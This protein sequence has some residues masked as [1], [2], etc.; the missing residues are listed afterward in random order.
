MDAVVLQEFLDFSVIFN[1]SVV[2][3][4]EPAVLTDLGVGV[5]VRRRAMGR[6]AGMAYTN[7][8]LHRAAALNQIREDLKPPLGLDHLQAQGRVIDRHTGGIVSA[9]FQ[10]RQA[11]QQDGRSRFRSDIAYNTTHM[12]NSFLGDAV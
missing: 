3:H 6:P 4:R 2:Y 8:A 9:I 1:N 5:D 10:P 7:R 11:V 12:N